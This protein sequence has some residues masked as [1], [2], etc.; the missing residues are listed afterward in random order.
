MVVS[1]LSLSFDRA[2]YI[3]AARLGVSKVGAAIRAAGF[4][5]APVE[6]VPSL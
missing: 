2:W 1:Q 6:T 3:S 4:M 5:S